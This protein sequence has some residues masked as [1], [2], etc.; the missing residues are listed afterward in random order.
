MKSYLLVLWT[1]VFSFSGV[2]SASDLC[3]SALSH[4]TLSLPRE[5]KISEG[6][7]R[8]LMSVGPHASSLG[9]ISRIFLALGNLDIELSEVGVDLAESEPSQ[10]A[11]LDLTQNDFFKAHPHKISLETK[12]NFLILSTSSLAPFLNSGDLGLLAYLWRK[13]P[14]NA[15]GQTLLM[16]LEKTQVA[17]QMRQKM[18]RTQY[19]LSIPQ[20]SQAF[21]ALINDQDGRDS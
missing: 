2:A 4:S 11:D 19:L 1:V 16:T 13:T 9:S 21:A 17:E 6:A 10:F 15:S 5:L 7:A 8:Y 20:Y 18:A 12:R 14:H 3:T